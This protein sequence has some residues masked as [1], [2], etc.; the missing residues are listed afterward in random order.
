[1]PAL[2]PRLPVSTYRLQLHAGFTFDDARG[3][4]AYLSSLGITDCYI[5]PPFAARPGSTHGYDVTNHNEF[6]QE[7]GGREGFDA[8]AAEV[9]ARG[10]GLILDFVPNHMGNDARTN[11]WWRD[12]LENGPSSPM[13]PVFDIDWDPIKP[14]L[15]HRLLLPILG[16]PYGEALEHGRLQLAFEDGALVLCYF[17]HRLPINPRR[18]RLVFE[19]D[20][21]ALTAALGEDHADLREFLSILTA[22]R[23]LPVYTVNDPALVAERHREKEVARERLVRLV[24]RSEA[25]RAHIEAAVVRFNGTVGDARSFDP[26]HDLLDQQPYRLAH[27]RTAADEINYRRFFDINDLAGLRVEDTMVFD[28]I[29]QLVLELIAAG[30]VTGLRLDHVD[31]LSDPAA[32]LERLQTAISEARATTGTGDAPPLYVVVEKILST[33]ETLPATWAA[34][35]TSG[36]NFLNDV[37]GL[38]VETRH[39]RRL[40]R[41]CVAFTGEASALEDVV[42]DSKRVIVGTAMS[43]EFQVLASAVNRLSESHRGSRDFTFG[44]IRRALREIVACFPVYRTYVTDRGVS[45]ADRLVMAAAMAAARA[46]NPAMESSIFAFLQ[47]ILLPEPHEAPR[48]A[49]APDLPYQPRLEVARKFQQ[50]TAPVQAKGVEDTAFYRYNVLLSLNEVGGDPDRFGH[51]V[52]EFH[53]ANQHRRA[54][55][56]LEMNATATHDTKRGEDAR[57]RLNALS[58]LPGPWRDAVTTWARLNRRLRSTA[59]RQ[60]APDRGDEYHYYQALLAVWPAERRDAPVPTQAPPALAE[61]LAGYMAKA[62]REAKIHTSWVNQN[63]DYE[64]AMTRFVEG[65]LAG[66]SA[67]RF[68]AEFVPFARRVARIGAIN[69]LS[70]LVLKVVSPGVP[71]FYQGTELWDLTL[72]DPDNRRPVDYPTRVTWLAEMEPS[73]ARAASGEGEGPPPP[74]AGWL[75]HWTDGRVKLFITAAGLRQRR[76]QP[77]LFLEGSYD[78]LGVVGLHDDHLVALG[79][80][81]GDDRVLAIAPRLVANLLDDSSGLA[82][83]VDRWADT[84]VRLPGQWR[85]RQWRHLCTGETVV[86]VRGEQEDWLLASALLGRCPVA[87]LRAV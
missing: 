54:H 3:A 42:Y 7:L 36:Y 75:D 18:G 69:S 63:A 32:Y 84:R 66:P 37:N 51:S 71:D 72:V 5:S 79:R 81:H 20:I 68:L 17:E 8:F 30:T 65:T 23:N 40:Q 39:R 57:A 56:P 38:F 49:G 34:A 26:L 45:D 64:A 78:P 33:N 4:T 50:Y 53:A 25:V 77:A 29:H 43:S 22:L 58:E 10:L 21:E 27:W 86:P 35:G 14:E 55:W 61:R 44:S 85:G 60:P 19:S 74:L 2:P 13:A 59:T 46:R 24:A 52:A 83:D 16:E 41:V 67:A 80:A 48:P 15:K 47:Q 76:A 1:M 82:L 31:G 28:H 70:Q 12:V 6:N 9:S 73:L 11:A 62:I 87:L